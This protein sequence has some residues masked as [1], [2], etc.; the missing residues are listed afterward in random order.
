MATANRDV[1]CN[2]SAVDNISAGQTHV[3]PS[4]FFFLFHPSLSSLF[5]STLTL[6]SSRRLILLVIDLSSWP[7]PQIAEPGCCLCKKPHFDWTDPTSCL[8]RQFRLT[9]LS[10]VPPKFETSAFYK[11]SNAA[12]PPP[13]TS[14][15]SFQ[16][17][18][19]GQ[20]PLFWC[21]GFVSNL[22]HLPSAS[23]SR[24]MT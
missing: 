6:P 7:S 20:M 24:F 9:C 4:P 3:P 12:L 14:V 13:N 23:I 8:C 15:C 17:L 5:L 11:C 16:G 21:L 1:T 18:E 19:L 22:D 10:P 2:S